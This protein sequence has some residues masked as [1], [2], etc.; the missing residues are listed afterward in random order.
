MREDCFSEGNR[1]LEDLEGGIKYSITFFL[2]NTT[3]N[4]DD[5]N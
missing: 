3:K 1:Y 4:P 2:T 5:T